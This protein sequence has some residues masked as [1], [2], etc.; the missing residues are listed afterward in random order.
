MGHKK[1]SAA[2]SSRFLE[3]RMH[4]DCRKILENL[5]LHI[6]HP[7][8]STWLGSLCKPQEVLFYPKV[9]PFG[10]Q[11]AS[12]GLKGLPSF[13]LCWLFL[14]GCQSLFFC[15]GCIWLILLEWC[16]VCLETS[17]GM[18]GLPQ[19]QHADSRLGVQPMRLSLV[20]VEW[21]IPMAQLFFHSMLW[22]SIIV[23][24]TTGSAL[25]CQLSRRLLE[26][27]RFPPWESIQQ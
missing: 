20:H 8:L 6:V 22:G 9:L 13:L 16:C 2:V 4:Q 23:P 14:L 25:V 24:Q 17:A 15:Q 18:L 3:F 19:R 7:P 21:L 1:D 27:H 5:Y 10:S 26:F 12:C 11:A